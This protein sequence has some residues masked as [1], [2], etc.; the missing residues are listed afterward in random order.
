MRWLVLMVVAMVLA[1]PSAAQTPTPIPTETLSPYAAS[2]FSTLAPE[3]G[4]DGQL[5][6]FDYVTSAADVHIANL[7][8]WMLFSG[9]GIFLYYVMRDL[10][11]RR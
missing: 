1:V 10:L 2:V 3:T 8:T 9:W 7:L 4:G 6:R 11:R 5:M